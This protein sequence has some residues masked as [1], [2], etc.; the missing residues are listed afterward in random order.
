MHMKGSLR[1]ARRAA[2][3]ILRARVEAVADALKAVVSP[4]RGRAAA[5][6]SLKSN[7]TPCMPSLA[8]RH[9]GS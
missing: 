6:V 4:P 2:R 3:H 1:A 8:E 7:A 9:R 5:G